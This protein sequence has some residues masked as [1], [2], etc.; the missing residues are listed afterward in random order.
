MLTTHTLVFMDPYNGLA[1]E[2]LL[3]ILKHILY[4]MYIQVV[5][6]H[7]CCFVLVSKCLLQCVSPKFFINIDPSTFS[8]LIVGG[9][10]TRIVIAA[11]T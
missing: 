8:R 10:I 9:K 1:I 6:Y 3:V 7:I 5:T 11:L 4:K 2:V